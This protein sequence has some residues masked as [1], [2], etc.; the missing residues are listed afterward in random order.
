PILSMTV[1]LNG[2][3]MLYT[4]L[5]TGGG[6][7][8]LISASSRVTALSV[9]SVTFSTSIC[10]CNCFESCSILAGS[11][12]GTISVILEIFGFSVGPTEILSILNCLFEISPVILFNTPLLL[13]TVKDTTRFILP[14]RSF[15]VVL[16]LVQ[17]LDRHS[18]PV[19]RGSRS[20]PVPC[21][22]AFFQILP[23][24][25]A[26]SRLYI[27]LFHTLQPA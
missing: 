8:T 15:H 25:L 22:S 13:L 21:C 23:W 2:S 5:R 4:S 10:F 16:C 27:L 7:D 9:I 24:P 12:I 3:I 17:P 14:P 1:A 11:S 18:H 20:K 6:Q 19:R 26:R